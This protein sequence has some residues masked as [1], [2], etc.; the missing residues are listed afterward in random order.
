LDV[1]VALEIDIALLKSNY[2]A[3]LAKIHPDNFSRSSSEE[4]ALAQENSAF[5]NRAYKTLLNPL[6]RSE[7]LIT[8][9]YPDLV[10]AETAPS[11]FLLT[12][13]SLR[14]DFEQQND[15]KATDN[16]K[17][18]LQLLEDQSLITLNSMLAANNLSGISKEMAKLRFISRFAQ[19]IIN[20]THW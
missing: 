20:P 18:Q 7:Q 14:E 9:L 5:L 4:A 19:E 16:I 10:V 6:M 12:I 11:D 1:A 13:L 3:K 15:D 17:T 2:H 8:T